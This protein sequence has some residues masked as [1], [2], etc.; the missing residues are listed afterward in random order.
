MSQ[1]K[2]NFSTYD[3]NE[4]G[5]VTPDELRVYLILAGYEEAVSECL[6]P[7][8]WA[9]AFGSGDIS[10]RQVK[11][12]GVLLTR[13]AMNGELTQEIFSWDLVQWPMNLD[14]KCAV[15]RTSMMLIN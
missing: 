13:M 3:K 1:S 12:D 11:V 6:R 10:S 8:V 9:H 2:T 14:I 5:E 4:D 7:A 15:S